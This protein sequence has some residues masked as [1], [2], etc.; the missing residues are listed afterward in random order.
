[1]MS[2]EEFA[3]LV[4]RMRN[5]QRNYLRTHS[6]TSLLAAQSYERQVDDELRILDQFFDIGL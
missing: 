2:F 3:R 5:E 1:M 6:Q 4:W